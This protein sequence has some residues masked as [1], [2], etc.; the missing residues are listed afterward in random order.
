MKAYLLNHVAAIIENGQNKA[1]STFPHCVSTGFRD[2]VQRHRV[3]ST[4]GRRNAL[5]IQNTLNIKRNKFTNTI[6]ISSCK[7]AALCPVALNSISLC[8]QRKKGFKC[9]HA[10]S[11]FVESSFSKLPLEINVKSIWCMVPGFLYMKKM[12]TYQIELTDPG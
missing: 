9:F 10:A 1:R 7:S 12:A 3:S 11:L 8:P 4:C 2:L 5:L 6:P